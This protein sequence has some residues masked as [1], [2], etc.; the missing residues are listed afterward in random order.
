M[1]VYWNI[2]LELMLIFG[3]EVIIFVCYGKRT[4]VELVNY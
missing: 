2:D 4:P 1:R 3:T